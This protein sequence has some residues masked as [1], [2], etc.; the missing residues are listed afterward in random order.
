MTTI[1][2]D[3]KK[4]VAD[5]RT[6]RKH[7]WEGDEALREG[8]ILFL[9]DFFKAEAWRIENDYFEQVDGIAKIFVPSPKKPLMYRGERVQAVG[10]SGETAYVDELAKLPRGTELT[11]SK[12]FLSDF[13]FVSSQFLVITP[14]WTYDHSVESKQSRAEGTMLVQRRPKDKFVSIGSG[15]SQSLNGLPPEVSAKDYVDIACLMNSTSGGPRWVWDSENNTLLL[16]PE[17]EFKDV[18]ERMRKFFKDKSFFLGIA[19]AIDKTVQDPEKSAIVAK[20][21]IKSLNEVN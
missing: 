3:G 12:Y 13:D 11:D 19:A 17:P 10:V 20:K 5:S 8:Q 15:Y 4:L 1:A 2:W 14:Q 21:L 7:I 6:F 18:M 16:H 9:N